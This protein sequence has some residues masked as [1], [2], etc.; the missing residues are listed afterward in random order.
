MGGTLGT[1]FFVPPKTSMLLGIPKKTEGNIFRSR[2]VFWSFIWAIHPR[3]WMSFLFSLVFPPKD[4]LV[5]SHFCRA[6][7]RF[8]NKPDK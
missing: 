6:I 2:K 3:D 1:G 7:D 4:D 8:H 5:E